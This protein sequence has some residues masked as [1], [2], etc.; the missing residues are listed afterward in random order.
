[1]GKT[2]VKR[3]TKQCKATP[4]KRVPASSK[5]PVISET[6]SEQRDGRKL[7]KDAPR[8][9]H[10]A[11]RA[12]ADRRDPIEILIESSADRVPHLV[13][14]R[15]GR[16]LKSP[17]A[18]Y[19]GAAAIMAAD[20]AHTPVSGLRVQC[21]GDCHLLN[22]GVSA[23]PERRFIFDVNDFDESLPG[24]WEWDVKRLATSFVIAGQNNQFK[25]GQT[26]AAA[27]ACVRSYRKHLARFSTMRAIE[28][29]YE[30][31]DVS[32]LLAR[33][34]Q[35]EFRK[36]DRE[37]VPKASQDALEHDAA[38]CSEWGGQ[39][40]IHEN[41][42]LIYHPQHAEALEFVD[43]LREAFHSYR[44]TLSEERRVLLDRYHLVDHAVKVV[45]V[46]S[47][48]TRC[49]VLLLMAGPDDPLFL[50]VK[51]AT[52]S[53][54]EPYAGASAYDNHGQRVVVAQRLMQ[55]ASDLFLG[56]TRGHSGRHFYVRQLRNIKAK[57]LVE[58]YDSPTMISY[59]ES[60]GWVLAR[61]HARSGDPAR[62]SDYLG[63]SDRFDEAIADFAESYAQQ[64]E[65]DHAQLVRAVRE[66]RLPADLER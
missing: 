57:P 60:C 17:F 48:G 13:P 65:R 7:R 27:L 56:W 41:P 8:S 61:A 3:A 39:I 1:M 38:L 53:V 2:T 11:W 16:M 34:P 44:H 52:A 40:R 62:I 59:A 51:E 19:R 18:F 20:L 24:P 50:Q 64:N 30:R 42:P 37:G 63:T 6:K 32:D 29:W 9:S 22:F 43:N 10:A 21:C 47:V 15:Y 55:A 54:L 33:S 25:A 5:A 58:A 23:T 4:A 14:I 45:G 36:L 35:S 28:V 66:G 31:V 46:G 49:G 26:R 12:P